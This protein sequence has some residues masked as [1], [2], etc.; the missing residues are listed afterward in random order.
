MKRILAVAV[1]TILSGCQVSQVIPAPKAQPLTASA[2]RQDIVAMIAQGPCK[3]ADQCRVVGDIV[4]A[5]G[6][7]NSFLAYSSA[8]TNEVVLNEKLQAYYALQRDQNTRRG[9]V[10]DCS[11]VSPPEAIC[12][13]QRCVLPTKRN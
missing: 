8:G 5:C 1:L 12:V 9:I 4:K 13:E 11:F 3:N 7:F 10:S 2:A 6:G